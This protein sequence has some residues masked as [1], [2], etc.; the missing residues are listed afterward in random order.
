VPWRPGGLFED[1]T[2]EFAV[3]RDMAP[4]VARPG[5]P[6]VRGLRSGAGRMSGACALVRA[7][8]PGLAPIRTSRPWGYGT[9]PGGSSHWRH[10]SPCRALQGR[11]LCFSRRLC[12]AI[13]RKSLPDHEIKRIVAEHRD[14]PHPTLYGRKRVRRREPPL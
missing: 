5:G 13:A 10:I 12:V 7:Q 8:C 3:H 6:D 4:A 11:E 14:A 9:P 1:S 2:G